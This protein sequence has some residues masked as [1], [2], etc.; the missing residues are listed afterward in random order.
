MLSV[1]KKLSLFG[2]LVIAGSGLCWMIPGINAILSVGA[3]AGLTLITAR[4]GFSRGM[5]L[6]LT[7]ILSALLVGSLTM[8]IQAGFASAGVYVLSVT[9]PGLMMGRASRNLAGPWTTVIHGLIPVAALMAMFMYVYPIIIKNLPAITEDFHAAAKGAIQESPLLADFINRNY[10][11]A[12]DPVAAFLVDTDEAIHFVVRILPAVITLGFLA[13]IVAA[14]AGANYASL[15]LKIIFPRFRPFHL[16]RASGWWL[17]PTVVGL[18]PTVFSNDGFWFYFGLN[19]LIVSGHVYVLVGLAVVEA[20]FRRILIPVPIRII[21][22]LVMLLTSLISLFFL[23]LLGLA[24]SKFNFAR[25][26]EEN[27]ID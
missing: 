17:L 23:A 11:S 3:I 6:A 1:E 15:K 27:K 24:D 5:L 25:E 10:G 14:M 8:G 21:I 18:V 9:G 22:Y 16:W 2:G 12:E 13:V 4:L 19:L 26:N 7:G 20:F